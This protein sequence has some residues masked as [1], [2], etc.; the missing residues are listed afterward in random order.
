MKKTVKNA[1]GQNKKNNLKKIISDYEANALIAENLVNVIN[2]GDYS[3][4]VK[5]WHFINNPTE[6]FYAVEDGFVAA[7][8]LSMEAVTIKNLFGSEDFANIPAGFYLNFK[9]IKWLNRKLNKGA[10]G[11][12]MYEKRSFYKQLTKLEE[13]T[14]LKEED[15]AIA[16]N[17]LCNLPDHPGFN[18]V[19][20]V[21]KEDGKSYDFDEFIEWD[22]YKNQ[23]AYRKHQYVLVYYYNNKDLDKPL[24][25]KSMWKV[26]DRPVF[27][28]A[29]KVE[30]A[31]AVK[32]SY[33][34]RS[35]VKLYQDLSDRAYYRPATHSVNLPKMEQFDGTE[36]YYE[37]MFHEFSHSTGH[38]SLLNR[39]TLVGNCGFHSVTY[40]KEE[41]VAELSSLFILDDL[42]MM[43]ADV[44]KNAASYIAGWGSTFG[45]SIKHNIMNTLQHSLKA[46][47]L[48]LNKSLKSKRVKK[49]E[50]IVKEETTSEAVENTASKVEEAT[51][52]ATVK[53]FAQLKRDL[54]VGTLVKTVHNYIK[55]EKDGQIRG[56]AIVQSNAIAFEA[57]DLN[58]P[59]WIWWKDH[60]VEYVG[61]TFKVYSKKTGELFFEYAIIERKTDAEIFGRKE[62]SIKEEKVIKST[63]TKAMTNCITSFLKR[64]SKSSI[65]DKCWYKDGQQVVVDGH[66]HNMLL[67]NEGNYLDMEEM[68]KE[69]KDSLNFD[70]IFK[71]TLRESRLNTCI[72]MTGGEIRN[73]AKDKETKMLFLHDD[74]AF[75]K[76]DLA[77]IISG[78]GVKD[79]EKVTISW[80]D[81]AFKP[82]VLFFN[83]QKAVMCPYRA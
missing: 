18:A 33:L 35:K 48:V 55:P 40:S 68:T 46:A 79:D 32:E 81:T 44:F 5:H 76:K 24:D 54:Q 11:Q 3:S 14:L 53:S 64:N 71:E 47:E 17:E 36:E 41:L 83:N 19:F 62:E 22:S 31:E 51:T 78:L 57:N 29:E 30:K 75:N 2:N 42:M 37:T 56:I 61:N 65:L 9:E 63:R 26:G 50:I 58:K 43:T 69:E 52:T 67:L 13:E 15:L 38:Q 20:T 80:E 21:T 60:K 6:L 8:A 49:E 7:F 12:P 59:S 34:E 66:A 10:V 72:E 45:K 4:W 25:I 82:I 73:M 70:Y 16:Y 1:A 39:A 28:K 27:T 74:S 23:P 77:A